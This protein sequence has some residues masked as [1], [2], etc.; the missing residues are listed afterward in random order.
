MCTAHG[1]LFNVGPLLQTGTCI[2]ELEEHKYAVNGLCWRPD[3]TGF[4]SGGMDCK[5]AFWVS[6]SPL[7]GSL[8]VSDADGLYHR[9]REGNSL[10]HGTH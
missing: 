1:L 10:V 9:T 8:C 7:S 5:V 2:A 6:A 3:G 4:V